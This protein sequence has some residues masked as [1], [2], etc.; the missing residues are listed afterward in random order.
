MTTITDIKDYGSAE[1]QI[2]IV[3]RLPVY[4][5][6]GVLPYV[7]DKRKIMRGIILDKQR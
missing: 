1:P 2:P 7:C 6:E 5:A 4:R 3:R